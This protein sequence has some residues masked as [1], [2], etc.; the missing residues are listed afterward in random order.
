[1]I[2]GGK[3][4]IEHKIVLILS[5]NLSETFFIARRIQRDIITNVRKSSSK[6]PIILSACNETR[7]LFD[8]FC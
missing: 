1:M 7:I 5:T 8:I 4:T 6:L 2:F 3:K